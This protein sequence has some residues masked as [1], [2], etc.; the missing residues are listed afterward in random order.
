MAD[1]N[2]PVVI[3]YL[4]LFTKAQQAIDNNIAFLAN[5]TPTNADV[6]AQVRALTRQHD[7]IIRLLLGLLD[8]TT[9]T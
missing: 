4:G 6:V 9:G 8:D 1:P 2:D 7:A 5:A 3:R